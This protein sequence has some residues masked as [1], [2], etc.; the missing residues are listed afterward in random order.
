M[1]RLYTRA[2][3]D[4]R[5]AELALLVRLSSA[6][7]RLTPAKIDGRH[8]PNMGRWAG[9]IESGGNRR[10]Q[11]RRCENDVAR[12]DQ[13]QGPRLRG[14]GCSNMRRN[15]KEPTTRTGHRWQIPADSGI[16]QTTGTL[17]GC[18]TAVNSHCFF[19]DSA[20]CRSAHH[21]TLDRNSTWHL[22]RI[23]PGRPQLV[24]TISSI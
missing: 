6:V 18:G 12:T 3:T 16:R 5:Y 13:H 9:S 10:C 14:C 7:R 2:W 4:R 24:D 8:Q 22:G 17:A 21:A 19:V 15:S 1:R 11:V 20:L 23:F